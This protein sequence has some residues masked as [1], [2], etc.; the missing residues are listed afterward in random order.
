[1]SSR[2][3][4]WYS[5]VTMMLRQRMRFRMC[6]SL[7]GG[8]VSRSSVGFVVPRASAASV[9]MIRLI[10][11]SCTGRRGEPLS[12]SAA[13]R[14]SS[15]DVKLMTSWNCRKQRMLSRMRRPHT[16]ERTMDLKLSS[17]M[18]M[19]DASLASSV[20]AIPIA[21]PT[22]AARRA[23]ASLVPSPVTATTSPMD[24]SVTT[25]LCL[26]VG[27]ERASTRS[28]GKMRRSSSSGR[29]RNS[30]PSITRPFPS[31]IMPQSIAIRS[32]VFRLS[33]VTIRTVMPA[34]SHLAMASGTSWRK[35][36]RMPTTDI[37]TR[38][39]WGGSFQ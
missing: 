23:A 36:S 3:I 20:P 12:A 39:T 2:M 24:F 27:D 17:M 19:S 10:H 28:S 38:S 11:S 8:R 13:T 25:S 26:S 22:W 15:M 35:G 34:R 21:R 7:P 33:P 31:L 5:V 30:F 14:T 6:S 29:L 18:M 1:M 4:S 32:A 37:N 9:S 16:T